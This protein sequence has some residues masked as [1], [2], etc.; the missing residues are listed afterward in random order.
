[1]PPFKPT[2]SS[3][4]TITKTECILNSITLQ[5]DTRNSLLL[6]RPP[7]SNQ[8]MLQERFH[9]ES[10]FHFEIRYPGGDLKYRE[11]QQ[12]EEPHEG[13]Q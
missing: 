13:P 6:G 5:N 4:W 1:M 12:S 3:F 2:I 11:H 10:E 9:L 8:P 7:P